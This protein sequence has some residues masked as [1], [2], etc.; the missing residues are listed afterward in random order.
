[1]LL[2]DSVQTIKNIG[3]QR[4]LKLHRL[5]IYTVNDL[6]EYIPR[7]Y[8]DRS[9]VSLINELTG[10]EVNTLKASCAGAENIFA[11]NKT[12][13]RVRLKDDTGEIDA[14]WFNQPYM[15]NNFI[16][17]CKYIFTGKA[18]LR[19]GKT[20]LLV[21]EYEKIDDKEL[22]SGGRIVPVYHSTHKLSQKM[23]RTLI[24]QTLENTKHLIKDFMPEELKVKYNLCDRLFALNNIHFPESNESF[25]I[26]RRRLVFEELFLLVC[27][28]NRIRETVKSKREGLVF[29]DTNIEPLLNVFE[30]KL[31]SAQTLVMNEI[32][33]DFKSGFIMNR[34]VQ[35]DVGSGKTA[36]AMLASYIAINNGYQAV[37]MA[38][39]DIL[40]TQHYNT[41][42][43]YFTD[44]NCVLLTAS[45]KQKKV[46]HD[47]IKSGSARMIIG[48][49]AL[50]QEQVSFHNA[51]IIITDEQHRFGV[52][53][54]TVL[55]EKGS[56]PHVLV[57]TATPIPR[58][59]ALILYG[60]LDI[61][62]IDELPPGRQAIDTRAVNSSYR[63]RIYAFLKKQIDAGRQAYIICPQIEDDENK[64][65][66]AVIS[67]TEKLSELFPKYDVTCI[68]GKMKNDIK[69]DIML[70]FSNNEIK[71]LVS[72]TV[73]E[74]GINVLNA[75][76]MLIENADRFG[77]SALHQ[78]RGRVG[79][80]S[81]KSYC[82]LISDNK[83]KLSKERLD[84]LVKS[85]D[86]FFI[87]EKDLEL[88]G[89][90]DFF[91]VRQHGLPE[92]KIANLYKDMDIL[93]EALEAAK[94]FSHEEYDLILAKNE[95]ICL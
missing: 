12:I 5:D 24:K 78:L 93:K 60:D 47:Q 80:G 92:L 63:E 25:F 20:E 42:K 44:I 76:V 29:N 18:V 56:N 22:L 90:G 9:N 89:P 55:A 40:A 62:I 4:L 38:P 35:G 46:I 11:G 31:T 87:S 49:H 7:D 37:L 72:T 23:L 53:Q 54:R 26:A 82:I 75:T 57:M 21:S 83:S 10:G 8:D 77:L 15:K 74:V 1:M 64:K 33:D 14:V 68:H 73:I 95:R 85:N 52:R 59:L 19:Y 70:K 94:D 51:G 16:K 66:K 36:V 58:T 69:Q 41:F 79:R 48:T 91:G 6:I 88:R 61:S 28:L 71:I 39:T 43:K 45:V 86:G 81:E 84:C 32:I 17:G 27:R 67:Y 2:T 34:L 30:Y 65:T 13:T 3:E 50:I